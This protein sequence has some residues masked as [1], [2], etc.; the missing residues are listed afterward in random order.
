MNELYKI[1][2]EMNA[3]YLQK[4]VTYYVMYAMNHHQIHVLTHPIHLHT[5][6]RD[7]QLESYH[8][9]VIFF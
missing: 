5:Q 8:K 1:S 4:T 9:R 2:L 7:I 6:L 3:T